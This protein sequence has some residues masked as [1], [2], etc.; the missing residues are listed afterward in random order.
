MNA[1]YIFVPE[2]NCPGIVKT[3]VVPGTDTKEY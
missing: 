3:L 1:M 2:L